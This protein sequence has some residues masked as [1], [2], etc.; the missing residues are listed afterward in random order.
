[1]L[2]RQWYW[3][4]GEIEKTKKPAL[5]AVCRVL[6]EAQTPYA[7]VGGVALQV[8]HPDPRTTVDIDIAVLRRDAIPR[9]RLALADFR[10]TGSFEHS[11][12]W[13]AADGTPV[14]FTDDPAFASGIESAEETVLDGVHLRVLGAREL[15]RQKVRSGTDPAKTEV[16]APAGSLRRSGVDRGQRRSRA[17]IDGRGTRDARAA[18]QVNT[19]S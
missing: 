3:M 2:D 18:A 15:I 16:E 9:D 11:E 12:N 13:A 1:M 6:N 8:H 7:I 5:L 19:A 10:Q 14:Q 4:R 17:R